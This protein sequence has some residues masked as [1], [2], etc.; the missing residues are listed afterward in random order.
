MTYK[1]YFLVYLKKY[2]SI[3]IISCSNIFHKNLKINKDIDIKCSILYKPD[4]FQDLKKKINIIKPDY[5]VLGGSDLFKNKI[6]N[7]LDINRVKIIDFYIHYPE[8]HKISFNLILRTILDLKIFIFF[9][10]FLKIFITKFKYFF[11]KHHNK[12][13]PILFDLIFF[14]GYLAKNYI[15]KK[16]IFKNIIS[17]NSFEYSLPLRKLKKRKFAVFLDNLTFGHPDRSIIDIKELEANNYYFEMNKFF[18]FLKFFFKLDIIIAAHPKTDLKKFK[19]Y[20]ENN[21]VIINK[22]HDLIF[23]SE[24][25]MAHS[26][27]SAINFAVIYK[28]PIIFITSND[29]NR[30]FYYYKMLLF[31]NSILK[32][33]LIN[34]SKPNNF[35]K[36]KKYNT[37]NS[38]GYNEFTSKYL[39]AQD[40]SLL[41]PKREIVN[42]ILKL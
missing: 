12:K 39:K 14:S 42:N 17:L 6:Y 23:S 41:D 9:S 25:V 24:F 38:I 7:L 26:T 18:N 29:I 37:I 3:R 1:N 19:K 35:L 30:D 5:V 34:I 28:K 36:F 20:Y 27:T 11:T 10:E 40:A 15:L 33:P 32:Q 21:E 8:F 13:N 4:S 2:F 22:T 16:K 31:K